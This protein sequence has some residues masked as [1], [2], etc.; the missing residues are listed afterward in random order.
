MFCAMTPPAK[1]DEVCLVIGALL[2]SIT[3]MVD[4]EALRGTADLASPPIAVQ[5]VTPER[6]V[7]NWVRYARPASTRVLGHAAGLMP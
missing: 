5:D 6:G 3:K 1:R 7:L 4:L 2:R